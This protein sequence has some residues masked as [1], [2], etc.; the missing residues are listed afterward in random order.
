MVHMGG[1]I[2]GQGEEWESHCKNYRKYIEEIYT[3]YTQS[4]LVNRIYP[5]FNMCLTC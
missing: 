2:E 1:V 4:G 3:P 5:N